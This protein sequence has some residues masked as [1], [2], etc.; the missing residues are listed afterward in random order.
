MTLDKE[1]IKQYIFNRPLHEICNCDTLTPKYE[2]YPTREHF[3]EHTQN[4][5]VFDSDAWYEAN[6]WTR[7]AN[8]Y[9]GL[10][11]RKLYQTN[12]SSYSI[13]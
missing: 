13:Q 9:I 10:R 4:T 5:I 12:M 1:K 7:L 11:L 2:L 6:E 8:Y 3:E